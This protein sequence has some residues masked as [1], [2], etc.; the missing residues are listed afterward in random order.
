M[1]IAFLFGAEVADQTICVCFN[2]LASYTSA[3]P[4]ASETCE[5]VAG[6]VKFCNGLIVSYAKFWCVVV[7]TFVES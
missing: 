7:M 5:R 3:W 2:I 1:S 4:L 6:H